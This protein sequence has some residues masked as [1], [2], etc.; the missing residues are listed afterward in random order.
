MT[1]VFP[2]TRAT[3]VVALSSRSAEDRARALDLI[4]RVYREPMIVLLRHR[5]NLDRDAA[6]DVVQ[7]FFA[8]AVEKEWFSRFDPSR[9]RFRAFLR[10]CLED[11]AR[12][13]HRDSQRLKRGGGAETVPLN[14]ESAELASDQDLERIFDQEWARAVLTLAAQEL[15]RECITAGKEIAWIVYERYDLTDARDADRPTYAQ[16]AVEFRQ[17]TSQVTNY[18]TWAR[19]RMR[20]HVLATIRSLTSDDAEYR[21]ETALLLGDGMA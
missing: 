13:Q 15:R 11:F 6:E 14:P 4:A 21:A 8:R 9:G 19:R 1:P 16:L 20:A 17:P 12:T 10:T 3:L 18:L 7:E 2:D 5:W